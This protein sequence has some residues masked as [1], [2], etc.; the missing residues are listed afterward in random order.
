MRRAAL[1]RRGFRQPEHDP[2]A[3]IKRHRRRQPDAGKAR[4]NFWSGPKV[5]MEK[6]ADGYWTV[7]TPPLVPGLH[8]YTVI[9]DSADW[10][11]PL[12]WKQACAIH[13]WGS[14]EEPGYGKGYVAAL[15]LWRASLGAVAGSVAGAAKHSGRHRGLYAL[16]P[17]QGP[18]EYSVWRG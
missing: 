17:P 13:K 7:I 3:K 2:G 10:L 11:E 9:V 15:D 8:Y 12:I 18:H 4:V 5:D 16:H 6:Q 1:A 14:I